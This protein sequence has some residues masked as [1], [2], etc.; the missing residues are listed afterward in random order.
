MEIIF[1]WCHMLGHTHNH[2]FFFTVRNMTTI[3]GK[4][5]RKG[6][7][8]FS[9][10]EFKESGWRIEGE[11]GP[12]APPKQ[13]AK[14]FIG[15]EPVRSDPQPGFE[16]CAGTILSIS[17]GASG[18]EYFYITTRS[19]ADAVTEVTYMLKTTNMLRPVSR[20]SKAKDLLERL[21]TV[22]TWW[23][24]VLPAEQWRRETMSQRG[25]MTPP[26]QHTAIERIYAAHR[27]A[28]QQFQAPT[29]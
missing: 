15:K 24:Q 21:D 23:M 5:K 19:A 1:F 14:L 10:E 28:A 4:Q 7:A 29:S 27:A 25:E 13:C 17:I 6:R 20:K 3:Y 11:R 18:Q 16:V 22:A 2:W 9:S 26:E 12:S 8:A